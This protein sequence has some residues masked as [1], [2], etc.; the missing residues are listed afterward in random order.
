[1]PLFSFSAGSGVRVQAACYPNGTVSY[2]WNSDPTIWHLLVE[3][4]CYN[5]GSAHE[6]TVSLR[7]F[8]IFLLC[9]VVDNLSCNHRPYPNVVASKLRAALPDENIPLYCMIVDW[10]SVYRVVQSS[11]YNHWSTGLPN[12]P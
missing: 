4:Q 9:E 8:I 11:D 5:N 3:Y 7:T 6:Q 2:K 1:M 10:V 12:L